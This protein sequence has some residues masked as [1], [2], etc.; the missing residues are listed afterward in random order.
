MAAHEHRLLSWPI[1]CGSQVWPG[2]R[3]VRPRDIGSYEIWLKQLESAPVEPCNGAASRSTHSRAAILS[4][5][6]NNDSEGDD[7]DGG[8]NRVEYE[9]LL[10]GLM[11]ALRTSDGVDLD[12]VEDL[13]GAA[14]A[15][16]IE[17]AAQNPVAQG[18][19]VVE[20]KSHGIGSKESDGK[21]G[22]FGLGR[23]KRKL[24]SS[25]EH[26]RV[27]L[28]GILRLTDPEGFLFS[29]DV[30]SSVFAAL[31]PRMVPAKHGKCKADFDRKN[32]GRA[33][34]SESM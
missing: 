32:E 31:E 29:N 17:L 15:E 28:R 20:N 2:S 30:I 14:A 3:Q 7:E 13:F 24:P 6:C 34:N 33:K 21:P 27:S 9:S 26:C 4:G 5:E 23:R 8:E 25:G 18:L 10:E 22:D 12:A 1:A 11:V 16:A 19:A